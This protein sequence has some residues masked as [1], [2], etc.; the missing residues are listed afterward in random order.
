MKYLVSIKG[1]WIFVWSVMGVVW[2]CYL[3]LIW[4]CVVC[5]I[6]VSMVYVGEDFDLLIIFIFVVF[7]EMIVIVVDVDLN[8]MFVMFMLID[9]FLWEVVL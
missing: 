1:G 2:M 3:W 8:V 7:G 5:L 4:V 9:G 6:I